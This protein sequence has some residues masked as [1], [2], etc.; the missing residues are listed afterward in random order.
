MD[1]DHKGHKRW[2]IFFPSSF[3]WVTIQSELRT[4]F[5][6]VLVY[7]ITSRSTFDRLG[8]FQQ[9][10]LRVKGPRPTF[11]LVGN[12]CDNVLEREVFKAEGVA[13]VK[14]FGCL[15]LETSAKTTHNVELLFENL[16]HI[17]RNT[18]QTVI[19]K[20]ERPLQEDRWKCKCVIC[21]RAYL[22]IEK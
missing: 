21:W 18:P 17:L 12:Q 8:I 22:W 2:Q 4:R 14:S 13:L 6:C 20:P 3:V 11:M 1:T 10:M 7:S 9:A 5:C 19:L 16:I 15:F